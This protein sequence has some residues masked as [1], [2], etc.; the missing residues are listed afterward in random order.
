MSDMADGDSFLVRWAPR[1][2]SV[3]RII[4]AFLYMQHGAQ[5]LFGFHAPPQMPPASAVYFFARHLA[6]NQAWLPF[7]EG[8]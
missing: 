4:V 8:W 1:I 5:K 2:L 6:E 7:S 3:M